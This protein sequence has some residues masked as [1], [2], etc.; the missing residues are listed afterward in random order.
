MTQDIDP[1]AA[2]AE[3][4]LLDAALKT[5]LEVG[6]KAVTAILLSEATAIAPENISLCLGTDAQIQAKVLTLAI[7]KG[8]EVRIFAPRTAAST[9]ARTPRP[10]G[11][12]KPKRRRLAPEDR[13]EEIVQAAMDVARKVGY[14]Q[15]TRNMIADQ[16][17][18]SDALVTTRLGTTNAISQLIMHEAINRRDLVIIAQGLATNDPIA[19]S[20]P[21]ELRAEN[22]QALGNNISPQSAA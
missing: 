14:Q 9:T 19:I 2:I 7:A 4:L 10:P 17:G 15:V 8:Y 3:T 12:D 11:E 5:S 13:K 21:A 6:I 22:T 18:T 20:A 16:A 1:R